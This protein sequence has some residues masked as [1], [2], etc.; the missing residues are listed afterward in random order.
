MFGGKIT[1]YRRLAEEVMDRL[2]GL[3]GGGRTPWTGTAPLPGGDLGGLAL[4]AFER[5]MADRHPWLPPP[6]LRRLAR[7]YGSELDAVLGGARALA[8]L[9]TDLGGGF[10]ERELEW[11][12]AEEWARTAEDVLWRRTRLDLRLGPSDRPA[13]AERLERLKSS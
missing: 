10:T 5:A 8:D 3:L 6:L 13:I 9:G 4:P 2:G 12:R 7:S 1:T 11:L